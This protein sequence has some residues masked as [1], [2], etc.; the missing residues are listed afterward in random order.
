MTRS[1]TL[2]TLAL[3]AATAFGARALAAESRLAPG[4][5]CAE[6]LILAAAKTNVAKN[7]HNAPESGGQCAYGVRT[8]LQSSGVGGITGG[9]GNAIDFLKSLPAYGFVEVAAT[10]PNKA[11]P[12]SVIVF[13]G[14]DSASYLAT[15]KYGAPPG[16]WLGHVTI[17]GDD[18]F[19][20]TDARTA[21]AA[22]GW[23]KGVDV[24]RIRTV[25]G[26]FVPS[27]ALA[28]KYADQCP[29]SAPAETAARGTAVP[30]PAPRARAAVAQ[31]A[32]DFSTLDYRNEDDRRTGYRLTTPVVLQFQNFLALAPSAPDR[33]PLFQEL[34]VT[35][36]EAGPYDGE[37]R[38]TQ[39]LAQTVDADAALRSVYDEYVRSLG[40]PDCKTRRLT[41]D[42]DRAL[43]LKSIGLVGQDFSGR[44]P[45]NAAAACAA[46]FDYLSCVQGR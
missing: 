4:E 21:E 28:A 17:K 5:N 16:N 12:G 10:D 42:V 30:S 1:T 7:F 9:I 46:P 45:I 33:V 34:L 22:I 32:Q 29:K 14:P 27:A 8:S 43:C 6:V 36:R 44:T 26:I 35:L 2:R 37:G 13:A 20:Y 23:E 19:Y 38:L 25:A 18:G 3:A 11:I 24:E 41:A 31:S 40:A 39:M 15:G